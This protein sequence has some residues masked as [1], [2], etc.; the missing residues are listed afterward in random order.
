MYKAHH[1]ALYHMWFQ[2][3]SD[4]YRNNNTCRWLHLNFTY[5][6]TTQ[7]KN[8]VAH[9]IND[10][11]KMQVP[12]LHTMILFRVDSLVFEHENTPKNA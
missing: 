3:K 8:N 9:H 2:N 7:L 12:R 11:H 6:D 1:W 5:K 10:Y 4:S